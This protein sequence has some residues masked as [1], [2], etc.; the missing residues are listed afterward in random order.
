MELPPKLSVIERGQG[1]P[2]T[3]EFFF[4]GM[5]SQVFDSPAIPFGT[6]ATDD[7]QGSTPRQKAQAVM[8]SRLIGATPLAHGFVPEMDESSVPA[9]PRQAFLTNAAESIIQQNGDQFHFLVHSPSSSFL[10]VS[11]FRLSATDNSLDD[12]TQEI[13]QLVQSGGL[14]D[15]LGTTPS[16]SESSLSRA[17]VGIGLNLLD[18]ATPSSSEASLAQ[19]RLS[20]SSLATKRYI[21]SRLSAHL[22]QADLL[23]S[24]SGNEDNAVTIEVVTVDQPTVVGAE[25]V[26]KASHQD[27]GAILEETKLRLEGMEALSLQ[28]A[29]PNPNELP[30]TAIGSHSEVSCPSELAVP[31][32]ESSM[33]LTHTTV[34]PKFS[35]EAAR[36]ICQL[37]DVRVEDSVNEARAHPRRPCPPLVVVTSPTLGVCFRR[38]GLTMESVMGEEDPSYNS[39]SDSGSEYGSSSSGSDFHFGATSNS[40]SKRQRRNTTIYSSDDSAPS[41]ASSS[42]GTFSISSS[43]LFASSNSSLAS[44]TTMTKIPISSR[45][46]MPRSVLVSPVLDFTEEGK[47]SVQVVHRPL[48]QHAVGMDSS[49]ATATVVRRY[50]SGSVGGAGLVGGI[51]SAIPRYQKSIGQ[52]TKVPPAV[53]EASSSPSRD[54]KSWLRCLDGGSLL[55]ETFPGSEESV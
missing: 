26:K 42:T 9:T 6:P 22:E 49:H 37:S 54:D 2:D 5:R 18:G 30:D 23:W 36:Q 25:D 35:P 40:S 51:G 10:A 1:A 24:G 44:T 14:P 46:T 12:F 53:H 55:E 15:S 38:F 3:P 29:Q 34:S 32:S 41:S 13:L 16:A 17:L 33:A 31:Y 20:R 27:A 11:P 21:A 52:S 19:W 39:D 48:R 47:H 43:S 50:R 8:A 28:E 45:S 4:Q 7:E